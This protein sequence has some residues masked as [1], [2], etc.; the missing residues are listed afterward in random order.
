MKAIQKYKGSKNPE[1]MR[2]VAQSLGYKFSIWDMPHMLALLKKAGIFG[3]AEETLQE[4]IADVTT[5]KL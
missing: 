3:K 5:L 1:H 2:R 4:N